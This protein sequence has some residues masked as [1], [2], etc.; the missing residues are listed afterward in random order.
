MTGVTYVFASVATCVVLLLLSLVFYAVRRIRPSW[1]RLSVAVTRMFSF[2][3]EMDGRG[4]GSREGTDGRGS[5]TEEEGPRPLPSV[6][7]GRRD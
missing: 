4:V 1:F 7:V 6:K 2:T 5:P 3:V